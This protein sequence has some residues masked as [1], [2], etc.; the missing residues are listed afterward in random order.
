MFNN[1]LNRKY[2]TGGNT[3]TDD[4]KKDMQG[5]VTWIKSNVE[6]FKD[7]SEQEI[8]KSIS[9]MA[10][11]EEGKKSVQDLY[12]RYQ[13]S[14]KKTKF[15]DGGKFQSFICKHGRGGVNCGCG[16]GKVVRGQEG[17]DKLPEG[18]SRIITPRDTTDTYYLPNGNMV[19]SIHPT[20]GSTP[21]YR[22]SSPITL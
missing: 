20:D 5:F 13:K 4:Q 16:G 8:A 2:Q 17:I 19:E 22:E 12:T 15:E 11:S 3:P 10:K 6:G 9:D 7:K 21:R 18:T 14:K 1:P